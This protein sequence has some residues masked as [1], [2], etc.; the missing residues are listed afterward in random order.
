MNIPTS[1]LCF[2]TLGCS[3]Y[4]PEQVAALAARFGIEQ[5][6][7]RGLCGTVKLAQESAFSDA[8]IA[9]TLAPIRERGQSILVSGSSLRGNDLATG[10]Q[11]DDD[12]RAEVA[13][14]R[15]MGAKYL[16]VF[17]DKLNNLED[18]EEIRAIAKAIGDA[19]DCAW[20]EGITVLMEIHGHLNRVKTVAPLLEVLD[21]HP[22]FGILW[23]IQ[24]SDK[25]YGDDWETFYTLVRPY[26]RHVHIKDHRRDGFRLTLPGE[27]D[28]PIRAI[29]DRLS[30]DGYEG[31]FSLE[32]EKLWH[33]ELPPIEEALEKFVGIMG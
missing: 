9:R 12:V 8:E 33:P 30:V 14:A 27:G 7:I 15:R 2:S 13:L 22:G 16:R 24:H 29:V 32:W 4:T 26:V 5:L 25:I 1:R 20:A 28:I 21:G 17:P 19:A 6:E 23:D 18:K 3:D 10:K 31:C 11:T